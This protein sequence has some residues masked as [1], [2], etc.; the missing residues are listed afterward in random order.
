[1]TL[2]DRLKGLLEG[3][4]IAPP[5]T[6]GERL[7]E[8][9]STSLK[10]SEKRPIA[11]IIADLKAL[12]IRLWIDAAG[13]LQFHDANPG[14]KVGVDITEGKGRTHLFSGK[15]TAAHSRRSEVHRLLTELAVDVDKF[16]EYFVQQ[17][18]DSIMTQLNRLFVS[19]SKEQDGQRLRIA[20][21]KC[22]AC[23]FESETSVGHFASNDTPIHYERAIGRKFTERGWRVS[24]RPQDHR[25]PACVKK[26]LETKRSGGVQPTLKLVK[27]PDLM[28]SKAKPP[29]DMTREHRR[30]IFEKLNELYANETTGYSGDWTDK[31]VAESLGCPRAW[32]AQIREEN[33][34]PE[35][36][37][38]VISADLDK[39][40]A[41]LQRLYEVAESNDT[42]ATEMIAAADALR[43]RA[44]DVKRQ[45][46]E[47]KEAAHAVERRLTDIRG[48]LR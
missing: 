7:E 44:E 12:N 36:S 40:G 34:G 28:T 18:E 32:V 17:R 29:P 39:A 16:A 11:T 14:R 22:G 41:V 35:G 3:T 2:T 26:E 33:F 30:I 8:T 25:C 13:S 15:V 20:K 5:M 24:A 42:L 37:N 21:I 38:E 10:S 27:D 43:D 1:M 6:P 46:K 48:T 45:S 47:A 19:Q 31:K 9:Y 4:A 23:P